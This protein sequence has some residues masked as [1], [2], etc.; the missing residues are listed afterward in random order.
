M[1]GAEDV[2]YFL[3]T[4]AVPVDDGV[5]FELV[6]ELLLLGSVFEFMDGQLHIDFQQIG[7]GF[8]HLQKFLLVYHFERL[9]HVGLHEVEEL[10]EALLEFGLRLDVVLH[11]EVG[12]EL[13]SEQGT[14]EMQ[15]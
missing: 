9:L 6:D 10:S 7:E 15:L 5:V 12:L 14:S 1:V 13:D 8:Q 11:I 3:Q 2:Q 4:D